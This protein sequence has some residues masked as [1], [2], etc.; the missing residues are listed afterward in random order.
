MKVVDGMKGLGDALREPG[1]NPSAGSRLSQRAASGV[2]AGGAVHRPAPPA[3]PCWPPVADDRLGPLDQPTPRTRVRGS[4]RRIPAVA[5]APAAHKEAW[6]VPV[7][8]F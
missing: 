5:H 1:G 6:L 8:Y 3:P 7:S 4:A 2:V